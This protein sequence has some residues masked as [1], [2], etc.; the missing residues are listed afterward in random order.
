MFAQPRAD[1]SHLQI[2]NGNHIFARQRL[3][4]DD[5]VN[6]V[7]E[8]GP[9]GPLQLFF[10][11]LPALFFFRIAQAGEAQPGAAVDEAGAHVAGHDDDRVAE[12][13]GAALTVGQAP[14][15]KDLQQRVPH[16]RVR[17]L[18][19]VKQHQAVGAAAHL[20]GELPTLIV[21]YIARRRAKE[22]ADRVLLA[23]LAHVHTDERILVVEEELRQRA[24]QLRLADAAAA[25]EDERANG[26]ARVAQARPA[27]AD[28]VGQRVDRLVL[29]DDALVQPLLHIQELGCFRFHHLR[30]GN[31]GP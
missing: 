3:E 1:F 30:H 6:A 24:G 11:A 27:A 7:D 19:L 22:T 2:D 17:L 14:I 18:D 16:V 21:A 13:D 20:F 23:V 25:Q 15:V 12:V 10:N 31:A 26:T 5:L 9:E 28:S 4:D 29:A 8:L